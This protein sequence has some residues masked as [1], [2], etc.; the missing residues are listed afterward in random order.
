MLQVGLPYEGGADVQAAGGVVHAAIDCEELG[1]FVF[2]GGEVEGV[3][4][5]LPTEGAGDVKGT[6]IER[7]HVNEAHRQLDDDLN[8]GSSA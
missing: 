5:L 3:V 6:G 1:V 4:R 7:G 8:E 2:S